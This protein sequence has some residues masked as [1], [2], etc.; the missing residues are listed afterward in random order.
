[1]EKP[2]VVPEV[3]TLDEHGEERYPH[4]GSAQ[5]PL[6]RAQRMTVHQLKE[7]LRSRG[8]DTAAVVDK[9]ELVQLVNT[10]CPVVE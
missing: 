10:H 1:M 5:H 4:V 8:V 2:P 6:D 9:D 3:H 7:R